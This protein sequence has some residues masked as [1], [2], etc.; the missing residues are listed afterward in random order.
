M[1]LSHH[2]QSNTEFRLWFAGVKGFCGNI[3]C[4]TYSDPVR[5]NGNYI[6]L[7]VN[8]NNDELTLGSIMLMLIIQSLNANLHILKALCFFRERVFVLFG[9]IVFTPKCCFKFLFSGAYHV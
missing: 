2:K 3:S 9:L 4:Y 8:V 1:P 5:Q 7:M 6:V